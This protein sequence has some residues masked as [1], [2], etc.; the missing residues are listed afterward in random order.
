MLPGEVGEN[1]PVALRNRQGTKSRTKWLTAAFWV[2]TFL[3]AYMLGHLD[4][5]A[6]LVY[7]GAGSALTYFW[8][9]RRHRSRYAILFGST[10]ALLA[11][12]MLTMIGWALFASVSVPVDS[13]GPRRVVCG[14]VI[15]PVSANELKVTIAGSGDSVVQ[16]R[17]IPQSELERVCS[18]WLDF[19]GSRAVDLALISLFGAVRAAGHFVP[20]RAS[21]TA[22]TTPWPSPTDRGQR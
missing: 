8:W 15:N 5:W 19:R 11:V 17:P 22:C 18:N 16:S 20:P 13:V 2:V 4:W 10:C 7:F 9:R 14:S 1:E 3:F 21:S 6:W 12:M